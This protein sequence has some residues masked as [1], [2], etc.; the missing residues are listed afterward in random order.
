MKKKKLYSIELLEAKTVLDYCSVIA[1]K[2]IQLLVTWFVVSLLV[3]AVHSVIAGLSAKTALSAVKQ[4]QTSE[5][6]NGWKKLNKEGRYILGELKSPIFAVF[7]SLTF[8]AF[9]NYFTTFEIANTALNN[10][11]DND[12]FL[13]DL[14]GF[15][16]PDGVRYLMLFQQSSQVKSLGGSPAQM[17][18]VIMKNGH[19]EIERKLSTSDYASFT[20]DMS[21]RSI[22][23]DDEFFKQYPNGSSTFYDIYPLHIFRSLLSQT[24]YL[25][26]EIDAKGAKNIYEKAYPKEKIDGVMTFDPVALGYLLQATGP[27]DTVLTKNVTGKEVA[28]T[29]EEPSVP[30]TITSKN[31]AEMLV[32]GV[33]RRHNVATFNEQNILTNADFDVLKSKIMD[34]IQGPLNP[35]GLVDGITKILQERRLLAWFKNES[36]NNSLKGSDKITNV[37]GKIPD[38]S[39]YTYMGFYFNDVEPSKVDYY[40]NFAVDVKRKIC[41]TQNATY[42]DVDMRQ[43]SKITDTQAANLPSYIHDGKVLRTDFYAVAP[44]NAEFLGFKAIDKGVESRLYKSGFDVQLSNRFVARSQ[45]YTNFDGNE[46]KFLFKKSGI[47]LKPLDLIATPDYNGVKIKKSTSLGC[48]KVDDSYTTHNYSDDEKAAAQQ[49][50]QASSTTQAK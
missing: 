5:I 37:S 28:D 45:A 35:I 40:I 47:D 24:Q 32:N 29:V 8:K 3:I 44:Q 1:T 19:F 6:N 43:K 18:S 10:V 14:L 2:V 36:T 34:A 50:A 39:K 22:P 49:K 38:D 46:H 23:D 21:Y 25:D 16:N 12:A 48:P 4:G 33:Y 31:A 17:M 26:F 27:I 13:T 42:Y 20:A 9:D 11:K 15:N 7:D 30:F 41:L